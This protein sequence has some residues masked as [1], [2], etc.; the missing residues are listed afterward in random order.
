MIKLTRIDQVEIDPT[1]QAVITK[2]FKSKVQSLEQDS[3]FSTYHQE[4]G[5]RV[6]SSL[7]TEID[8]INFYLSNPGW[9]VF[10]TRMKQL[11]YKRFSATQSEGSLYLKAQT[12]ELIVNVPAPSGRV[13]H[14]R[15]TP[16]KY[17]IG[18]YSIYVPYNSALISNNIDSIHFIPEKNMTADDGRYHRRHMHHY[19]M[20]D[21]QEMISNPLTYRPSTCWGNFGP[22]ISMN[23]QAGD[24]PELFRS[25]YLYVTIQNVDSPLVYPTELFFYRRIPENES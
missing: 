8:K 13:R 5:Q 3:R 24:I 11:P 19:A 18:A 4:A 7:F 10:L 16:G 2:Y 12:Q 22:I 1:F 9:Q 23:L 14:S 17:N 20:A 25:L 6:N 15:L 21:Q